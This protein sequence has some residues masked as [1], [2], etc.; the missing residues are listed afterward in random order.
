MLPLKFN[1]IYLSLVLAT[2]VLFISA[3][4]SDNDE[5]EKSSFSLGVS[6]APIDEISDLFICFSSVELKPTGEGE[7]I[8][9]T[10]GE[11]DAVIAP[12]SECP[13][14]INTTGIN[15]KDFIGADAESFISN[16]TVAQGNYKMR[17]IM[18]EGS[19][20]V[21]KETGDE[22]PVTV[23]SNEL[24]LVNTLTFA[25]G[26]QASYTLEFDLKKSM[27]NA[28]GQEGYKLKPTGI[29]LVNNTEVGTLSGTVSSTFLSDNEISGCMS[30]HAEGDIAA[31]IYIYEGTD[32]PIVN[33]SDI[34]EPEG[35]N[36][37]YAT[38]SAISDGANNYAYEIGYIMADKTYTV[39][40]TCSED[41]S[42]AGDVVFIE[43]TKNA[44]IQAEGTTTVD[45]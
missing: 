11:D 21:D 20:A 41:T 4:G 13:D 14:S 23:P 1:K 44:L 3:C 8:T 5:P 37:P 29:R 15:V 30:G 28:T 9:F 31:S 6:D 33:M 10:V 24:K 45:F 12:N 32:T 43:P 42:A 27:V 22:I 39:A 16:A 40:I 25:Q 38:A 7:V 19:F 18:S 17:V 26:G 34:S 2:S 36:P 35:S